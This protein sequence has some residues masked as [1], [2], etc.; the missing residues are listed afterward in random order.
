MKLAKVRHRFMATVFDGLIIFSCMSV[1][2]LPILVEFI[3]ALISDATIN[4]VMIVTLLRSGLLYALFLLFYYMVLPMFIKGQ[5]IGK[6][7]FKIKV[8]RDDN[9]DVDYKTLFFREAICRILVT[10]LSLGISA[11][12]SFIIMIIRDDKKSLADVFANTKVIDI[13]E[14]L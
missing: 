6:W 14:G 1:L 7:F 5:T 8:L 9:K 2:L 13:K 4:F 10:T 12:V 3:Y 11:V